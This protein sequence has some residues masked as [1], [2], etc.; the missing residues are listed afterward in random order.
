LNGRPPPPLRTN[1][2]RVP[3]AAAL[4]HGPADDLLGITC[5]PTI[6]TPPLIQE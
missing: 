2:K 6:S 5:A 1:C 4:I 3:G